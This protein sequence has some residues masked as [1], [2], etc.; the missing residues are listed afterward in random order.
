MSIKWCHNAKTGEVF[1]YEVSGNLTDF[2]RGTFIA[3]GDYL[4]TGFPS[5]QE[6]IDWGKEYGPCE[7]CKSAMPVGVCWKCGQEVKPSKEIE[8]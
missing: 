5:K 4:T 3:H 2:P 7:K 6:A 8:R 1:S